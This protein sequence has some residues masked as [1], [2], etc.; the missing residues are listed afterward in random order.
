MKSSSASAMV[1]LCGL[2]C[3]GYSMRETLAEGQSHCRRGASWSAGSE[4]HRGARERERV[5]LHDAQREHNV[6]CAALQAAAATEGDLL[7]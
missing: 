1:V 3:E 2:G 5:G 7:R 4:A 6:C